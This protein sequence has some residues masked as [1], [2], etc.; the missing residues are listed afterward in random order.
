[1][2]TTTAIRQGDSLEKCAQPI[3]FVE[4]QVGWQLQLSNHVGPYWKWIDDEPGGTGRNLRSG[5]RRRSCGCRSN[6]TA[7]RLRSCL[8]FTRTCLACLRLI[9]RGVVQVSEVGRET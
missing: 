8:L 1:A 3:C 2:A 6:S 5:R 4:S 9:R 7:F